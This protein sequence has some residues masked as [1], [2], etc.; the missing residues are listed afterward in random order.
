MQFRAKSLNDD[1]YRALAQKVISCCHQKGARVLLNAEPSLAVELGADGV[2]LSSRRLMALTERPLSD[3][4]V[5]AA[6]C[7]NAQEL[8]HARSCGLN[9]SV[10]GAVQATKSHPGREA[11]G[12][13]QAGELIDEAGLPVFALGGM[14]EADM[15]QA[16]RHGAQGVAAIR[17]FWCD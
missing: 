7:H 8:A 3:G 15:E 10:L 9:F 1:E 13:E 2:H 5:C 16:W 17:A 14:S 11:L 12:W 4:F 6:S